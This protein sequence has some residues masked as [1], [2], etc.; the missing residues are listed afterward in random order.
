MIMY[1]T[2]HYVKKLW[3][4]V[5]IHLYLVAMVCTFIDCSYYFT[6]VR[7][8]STHEDISSQH[9]PLVSMEKR[10]HMTLQPIKL[11][12]FIVT[13]QWKQCI[14]M[15][16]GLVLKSWNFSGIMKNMLTYGKFFRFFSYL[17][18]WWARISWRKLH[19]FSDNLYTLFL[20]EGSANLSRNIRT[21]TV[22]FHVSRFAD[23]CFFCMSSTV[24][25]TT[26][27]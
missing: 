20:F 12:S 10:R 3:R 22:T 16:L 24:V 6:V 13:I 11:L 17:R 2:Q 1:K 14:W 21:K 5:L 25:P 23:F 18:A 27:L 15:H 4:D 9:H 26:L 7:V 19:S 8:G